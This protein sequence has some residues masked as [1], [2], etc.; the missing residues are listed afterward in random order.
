M[1]LHTDEGPRL[2]AFLTLVM[3]DDIKQR[4]LNLHPAVVVNKAQVSESVHEKADPRAGC[5]YHFRQYLLTNLG[6]N[7]LGCAFLTKMS[8]QHQ[9][10]GSLFSLVLKS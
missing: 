10:S 2:A 1:T 7:G 9:D 8:Q 6:N 5:A 4:A 3:Q